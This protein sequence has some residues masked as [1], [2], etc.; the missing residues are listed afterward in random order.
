MN[1]AI[2]KEPCELC[3]EWKIDQCDETGQTGYCKFHDSYFKRLNSCFEFGANTNFTKDQAYK[4]MQ[5][6][7]KVTHRYFGSDEYIYIDE[8]NRMYAEDGCRFER[9]W[10]MRTE[11]FWK[12][13][14]A[15]YKK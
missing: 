6:G 14:W 1:K 4:L 5:N 9:G 15:V 11:D 2:P 10:E 3:K 7:H 8:Q 12:D 13:G